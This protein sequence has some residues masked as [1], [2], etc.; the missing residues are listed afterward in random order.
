MDKIK[1]YAFADEADANIDGQI[2]AM[3]ENELDG[4]EIRGVDGE[5]IS[6]IS[7][8]KAAEVKSK[9]DAAGL[10]VWSIGSPIGK[11]DIEKDDFEKEKARFIHTLEVAKIL[12]APNIRLF[13][14]FIP[15][16]KDPKEFKDE[17]I[18]RLKTYVELAKGYDIDLCH[19][20]EKGIYGDN[21]E[22]CLEILTEVPELKGIFD[23]ANFIQ[24]GVDTKAAWDMLK[25]Y[26]K[27]MHIKD[28][29]ADG[30]VVP[31]GCGEGNLQEIV[32][33]FIGLGG[34]A[35][36]LEPHLTIFSGL[37]GLEREGDTSEIGKKFVYE[38]PV[39]AFNAA[40]DAFKNIASKI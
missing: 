22:R 18:A 40:C 23:P 31:A 36:T 29:L 24:C 26:I 15:K 27:Y 5:N 6:S 32:G 11:I 33:D 19:E 8:E 39:E 2:K 13:S 3:Q 7:L 1:I 20:N 30:S 12:C 28:A 38:S 17:V 9:L 4:L 21:A 35:F 14:F 34:E 25:P 16:N 10:S 37:E